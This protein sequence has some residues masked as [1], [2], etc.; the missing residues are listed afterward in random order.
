M[1]THWS[2]DDIPWNE[3]RADLIDP[4]LVKLVKAAALVE[5]NAG[6]YAEYLCNVFH[7]DPEFQKITRKWSLEEIQHGVVL[8]RWAKMADA[9]FDYD[10]SFKRFREGYSVPIDTEESV[11]GS[12]SGELI[13]RCMVEVGT[14]SYYT[15]IASATEEPVLREICRRIATDEWRHYATFYK[16]LKQYLEIER[17][18]RLRRLRIAASRIVESEDDELAYAFYAANDDPEPYD[19]KRCAKLY[20]ERAMPLYRPEHVERAMAMVLK[21]VGF[22]PRGRVNRSLTKGFTWFMQVRLK[23]MAG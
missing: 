20:L 21:A 11:R 18:S 6:D 9:A 12:R 7:D 10:A 8:G 1:S 23:F 16:A 19:R 22:E 5:S 17:P 14:S 15:A 2:I 4:E 13:A 3:F